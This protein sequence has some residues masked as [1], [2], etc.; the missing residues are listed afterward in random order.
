MDSILAIKSE[1][2]PRGQGASRHGEILDAAKRLFLTDGFERTTI[3]KIAAAVGVSSAALY[4]YFPDK[5]AILRAIAE[6]TFEALLS[7]LQ[8]SQLQAGNDLDRFRTG[9]RAYI[10]FGLAHP[11]EYRLTF[12]AKM[13]ASS[14]PGRPNGP[15][16]DVPAAD[17]SFD[18]L[19]TSIGRLTQAGIFRS[20]DPV[21]TAEAVWASIHGITALLLDQRDHLE[22]E[23]D[24]LIEAVIDIAVRGLSSAT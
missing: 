5:D 16:D 23:T 13:M 15:C 12:L 17:R 21:L 7:R 2:K 14:G 6:S 11:D 22:S 18:I 10:A 8:A 4:L 20:A 1:R 19:V 9:L 3:R 24:A